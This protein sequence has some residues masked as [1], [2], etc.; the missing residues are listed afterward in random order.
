MMKR[1]VLLVLS[2]IGFMQFCSA[3]AFGQEAILGVE[4]PIDRWSRADLEERLKSAV[5]QAE[6]LHRKH[7]VSFDR[8]G[9]ATRPDLQTG[10]PYPAEGDAAF[11]LPSEALQERDRLA[12]EAATLQ[13]LLQLLDQRE[14]LENE[15]QKLK[16]TI[17]RQ[18]RDRVEQRQMA[19]NEKRLEQ[20]GSQLDRSGKVLLG[21]ALGK[22]PLSERSYRSKVYEGAALTNRNLR[23]SLGS[24]TLWAAVNDGMRNEPWAGP[25]RARLRILEQNAER[26]A[27]ELSR[28]E[29]SSRPEQKEYYREAKE[30]AIAIRDAAK[31]GDERTIEALRAPH[32]RF[33][34]QGLLS[35]HAPIV[36]TPTTPTTPTTP[37]TPVAALASDSP[38]VHRFDSESTSVTL[39]DLARCD[40]LQ[41][42]QRSEKC[43]ATLAELAARPAADITIDTLKLARRMHVQSLL[44][45][46]LVRQVDSYDRLRSELQIVEAQI[47]TDKRNNLT[48]KG[49]SRGRSLRSEV[50]KARMVA[51]WSSSR[52][53]PGSTVLID[54]RSIAELLTPGEVSSHSLN[55]AGAPIRVP[56]VLGFCHLGNPNIGLRNPGQ[57]ML[58]Q[59]EE[60]MRSVLDNTDPASVALKGMLTNEIA[61]AKQVKEWQDRGGSMRA[62]AS[63]SARLDDAVRALVDDLLE[64]LF[65]PIP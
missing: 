58:D 46:A 12:F 64:G 62:A 32:A 33:L 15:R 39:I 34:L 14:R 48:P 11:F 22:G 16:A 47:E 59:N 24:T 13:N 25:D 49:E 53:P 63:D 57:Y 7:G 23:I 30:L 44:A 8:S 38:I 40:R 35:P 1:T 5:A 52:R 42:L 36:A 65:D 27:S 61:T 41:L 56:S 6:S 51:W 21:A 28:H 31:A 29:A 18:R 60:L 3:G 4:F 45:T 9:W 10:T 54:H 17:D 20:L 50:E 19:A 37:A 43:R 55:V 2:I 26:N